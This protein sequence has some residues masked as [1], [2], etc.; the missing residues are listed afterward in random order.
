MI[1]LSDFFRDLRVHSLLEFGLGQIIRAFHHLAFHL[2]RLCDHLKVLAERL[3][4]VGVDYL[5][6]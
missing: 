3:L 2:V 1:K 5:L 4:Q 6:F